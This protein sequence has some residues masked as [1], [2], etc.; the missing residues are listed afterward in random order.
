MS[1]TEAINEGFC[2]EKQS[3]LQSGDNSDASYMIA[4]GG[5]PPKHAS[6]NRLRRSPFYRRAIILYVNVASPGRAE[7]TDPE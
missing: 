7:E 6:Q 2:C 3:V 1:D 5:G 4:G